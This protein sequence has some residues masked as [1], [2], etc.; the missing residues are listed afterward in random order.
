M[1]PDALIR[2]C[3][4]DEQ[5]RNEFMR[6]IYPKGIIH[7]AERRILTLED[8]LSITSSSHMKFYIIAH[9]RFTSSKKIFE[10][11]EYTINSIKHGFYKR[12][13]LYVVV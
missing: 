6:P 13:E 3:L 9:D 2:I 4:N 1:N 10:S 12:G 5:M 8:I 11:S 7:K